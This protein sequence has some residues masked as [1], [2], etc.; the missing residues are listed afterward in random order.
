MICLQKCNL[1][2]HYNTSS[3]LELSEAYTTMSR[4]DNVMLEAREAK[5]SNRVA[6]FN[7]DVT[8]ARGSDCGLAHDHSLECETETADVESILSNTVTL[9]RPYFKWKTDSGHFDPR[10]SSLLGRHVSVEAF[11]QDLQQLPWDLCKETF[12]FFLR[13]S[14]CSCLI[15]AR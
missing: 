13:V 15:W 14:S 4:Y 5:N 7:S 2:Q 1:L 3:W 11:L 12:D 9:F 8:S 10:V 6:N